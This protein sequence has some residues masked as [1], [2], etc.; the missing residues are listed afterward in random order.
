[1]SNGMMMTYLASMT[2]LGVKVTDSMDLRDL[3]GDG[4]NRRPMRRYVA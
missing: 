3:V 1:M 2:K 4:K